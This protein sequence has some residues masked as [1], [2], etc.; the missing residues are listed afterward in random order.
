[1]KLKKQITIMLIQKKI[2]EDLGL[3]VMINNKKNNSGKVTI[4]YKN[5]EQFDLISR[6]LKQN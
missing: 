2:E 3:K 5:L 4:E 1:M 6:L